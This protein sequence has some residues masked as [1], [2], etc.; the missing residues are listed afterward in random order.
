MSINQFHFFVDFLSSFE[1]TNDIAGFV[2][3]Q[4]F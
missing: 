3:M 1:N 4:K 2:S